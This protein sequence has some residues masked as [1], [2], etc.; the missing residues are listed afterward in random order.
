MEAVRAPD[1]A[2][3]SGG[4]G[5]TIREE[6]GALDEVAGVATPNNNNEI[7]HVFPVLYR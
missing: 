3:P 1:D 5:D 4:D 2:G 6:G 7:Y